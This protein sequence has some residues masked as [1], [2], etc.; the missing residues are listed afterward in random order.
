MFVKNLRLAFLLFLSLTLGF[1]I[2]YI[3]YPLIAVVMSSLLSRT[4]STT[5]E[6]SGIAVVAGGVSQSVMN[7]FLLLATLCFLI[8]VAIL[9]KRSRQNHRSRQ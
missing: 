8:L 2:F 4:I 6:S 9:I 7:A 1:A 5:G 3:C